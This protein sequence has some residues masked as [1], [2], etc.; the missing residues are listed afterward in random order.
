MAIELAI[1]DDTPAAEPQPV[2]SEQEALDCFLAAPLNGSYRQYLLAAA[3]ALE[4]KV[5]Q[6]AAA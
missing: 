2:L 6:K 5:L 4:A 1:T 3:R